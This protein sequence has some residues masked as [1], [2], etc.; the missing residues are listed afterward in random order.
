MVEIPDYLLERSREARAQ[1]TGAASG[2]DATGSDSAEVTASASEPT[3]TEPVVTEPV[4]EKIEPPKPIAPWVTAAQ[5]RKK[6]PVWMAPVALFLPIWAFM[7][8]GTLE[9]PTYDDEGPVAAGGAVYD[10]NCSSCHGAGGGGGVGYQLN[11]GEVVKTFPDVESHIAWVV[12][13]SSPAGTPY[14]DSNREGGQR[15]AQNQGVMPGFAALESIEILE[16]VL[17]ERVT[18]GLEGTQQLEAYILWA[19][20]GELPEWEDGISPQSISA[21]FMEFVEMNPEALEAYEETLEEAS[22]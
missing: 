12:N 7:I 10:A 4:I 8:W 15:I 17:Y 21:S 11:E 6:I 9:K 22:S 20:S 13:G 16:V 14:G 2:N 5:E 19:E 1:L 3:I 18:H